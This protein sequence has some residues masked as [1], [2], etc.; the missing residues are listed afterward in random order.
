MEK[1]THQEEAIML[2]IWKQE[3]CAIKDV[4]N[5]LPDPRPPYTTV[6]SV[7]RN[8]K[9]KGYVSTRKFGSINVFAPAISEQEY[10][11]TFLSTVVS[12]YFADSYKELVSFFVKEEKLSPNDLQDII[13]MIEESNP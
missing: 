9:S 6:A 1:L 12:N 2:H 8:L 11:K 4:W 5:A 13:R 3:M 7:F 10:K